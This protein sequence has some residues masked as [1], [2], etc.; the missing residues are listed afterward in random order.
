M[1]KLRTY[2][3]DDG[4]ARWLGG[5]DGRMGK[6]WGWRDGEMEEWGDGEY[7]SP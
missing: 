5:V 6:G 1:N 3:D 4:V 2:D 7:N